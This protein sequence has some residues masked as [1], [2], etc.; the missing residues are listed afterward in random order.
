MK[1]P[2]SNKA[3]VG[4]SASIPKR[5][6][7]RLARQPV[8]LYNADRYLKDLKFNQ[9]TNKVRPAIFKKGK[10]KRQAVKPK[11]RQHDSSESDSGESDSG[12]SELRYLKSN[13]MRNI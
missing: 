6:S 12:S 4:S 13:I 11:K 9:R 2:A 8:P 1:P 5:A 7:S 10:M 3:T